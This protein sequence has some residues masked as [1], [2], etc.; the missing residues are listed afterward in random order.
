LLVLARRVA[1]LMLTAL[2]RIALVLRI[3]GILI[4]HCSSLHER[5][6]TPRQRAGAPQ[7]SNA[8]GVPDAARNFAEPARG[9][10]VSRTR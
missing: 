10:V 9:T 7:R 2:V 1:L 4:G 6:P 3:L 5:P 8:V